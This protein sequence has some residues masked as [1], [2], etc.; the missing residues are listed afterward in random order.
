[1]FVR[2]EDRLTAFGLGR[3]LRDELQVLEHVNGRNNVRALV[4]KT[5]LGSFDVSRMLY[6]LLRNKLIRRRVPPLS[7]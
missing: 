4:S 5:Q 3:L 7:V 2:D 6:R 1:V